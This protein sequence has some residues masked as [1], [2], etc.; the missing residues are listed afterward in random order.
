VARR[1][2]RAGEE[3]HAPYLIDAEVA[4]VLR[5]LCRQGQITEEQGLRA[6]EAPVFLGVI[7]HPHVRLLPRAWQLRHNLS[8]YDALYVALAETL[9]VPLLTRDA[10]LFSGARH[11]PKIELI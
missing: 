7:R 2:L 10:R 9:G 11:Y 1:S 4:S 8:A 6:L 3:M 5:R